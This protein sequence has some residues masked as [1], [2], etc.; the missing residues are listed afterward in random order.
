MVFDASPRGL[1]AVS[2]HFQE[3]H[4]QRNRT[5][6][7]GL[8]PHRRFGRGPPPLSPSPEA[9]IRPGK[10]G[11]LG[12]GN[13]VSSMGNTSLPFCFLGQKFI[14]MC[15][16]LPGR[17]GNVTLSF[18]DRF[19]NDPGP[20]DQCLYLQLWLPV[21]KSAA[22]GQPRLGAGWGDAHSSLTSSPPRSPSAFLNL[23]T[24]VKEA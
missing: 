21:P 12:D 3:H 17:K 14:K 5:Y 7:G 6:L 8:R 11:A 24:N 9:T 23:R 20:H 4:T 19:L 22:M 1:N 15:C 16:L 2:D 18:S 10:P 13:A